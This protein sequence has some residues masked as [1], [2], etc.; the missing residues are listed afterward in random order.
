MLFELNLFVSVS[1]YLALLSVTGV[2][3]AL[4]S[5]ICYVLAELAL[6]AVLVAM[7][8]LVGLQLGSAC[9]WWM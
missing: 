9:V 6:L 7:V 3:S 2:C 1:A 5:V 4:P 8:V